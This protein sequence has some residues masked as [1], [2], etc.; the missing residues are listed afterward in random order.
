MNLIYIVTEGGEQQAYE[1][2]QIH[3]MLEQQVLSAEMLYWTEGMAEWRPLSELP[4]R[5][6]TIIAPA[7]RPPGPTNP[8]ASLEGAATPPERELSDRARKRKAYRRFFFRINPVPLTLSIQIGTLIAVVLWGVFIYLCL[9]K[10]Y[11]WNG[12]A[13]TDLLNTAGPVVNISSEDRIFFLEFLAGLLVAH[14]VIE[15]MFFNWVY[16][17]NK[18]SRA[19]ATNIRFQPE[20]AVQCFFVP[21]I[22][23]F[24]PYQIMQEIWKVSENPRSWIGRR[25]SIYVGFWFLVR[26][27]IL[28]LAWS[29]YV[30]FGS[31]TE[32]ANLKA[33]QFMIF[34]ATV[35]ADIAL[36]EIVTGILISMVT[37]RQRK[38][39]R[40][41]QS[42]TP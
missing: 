29:A 4:P 14:V 9:D 41:G 16:F 6:S 27:S 39:V 25:D 17:A 20:W 31:N 15:I 28:G 40:S 10:I 24:R 19:F 36:I 32:D 3:E 30:A 34:L 13:M 18:N 2:A 35:A 33:Q 1:E 23:L 7:K 42:A 8:F 37:W 11:G 26:W 38:W 12:G 21:I 5:K 22:N